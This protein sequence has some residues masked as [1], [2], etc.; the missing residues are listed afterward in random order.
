M[1]SRTML[2]TAAPALLLSGRASPTPPRASKSSTLVADAKRVF[3]LL[4]A[5]EYAK[6]TSRWSP[7]MREALPSPEVED[8]WTALIA[9][10]GRLQTVGPASVLQQGDYR[11]VTVSLSFERA[12]MLASVTFDG[13]GQI[14]GLYVSPEM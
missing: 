12:K 11:T 2:L 6:I 1:R 7:S 3:E 8:Y 5:G 9:V 14:V 10:V 13:A 4:R